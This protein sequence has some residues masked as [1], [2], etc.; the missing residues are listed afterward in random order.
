MT[1]ALGDTGNL[2]SIDSHVEGGRDASRAFPLG[3]SARHMKPW[4]DVT[5]PD[6]LFHDTRKPSAY[7]DDLP[8]FF[9]IMDGISSVSGRMR[10]LLG[11]FRRGEGMH[12]HEAP[13]LEVDQPCADPNGSGF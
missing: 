8:D 11:G 3:A 5:L 13:L 10:D 2:R 7:R 4:G 1:R 6:R 9:T 12:F